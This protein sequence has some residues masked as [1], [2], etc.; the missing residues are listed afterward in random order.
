MNPILTLIAYS[1]GVLAVGTSITAILSGHTY[2]YI[3]L[4]IGAG[5]VLWNIV[6]YAK[7]KP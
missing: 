4:C 5:A 7:E 6:T 3:T 1:L 2:S